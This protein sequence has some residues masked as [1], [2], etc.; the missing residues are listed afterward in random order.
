[1]STS[2]WPRGGARHARRSQVPRP[3]REPWFAT[4]EEKERW[5]AR[6]RKA[7]RDYDR[8][9]AEQVAAQS[10]GQGWPENWTAPQLNLYR[11][12]PMAYASDQHAA[13][14]KKR[15]AKEDAENASRRQAWA[16][17][18]ADRR[19]SEIESLRKELAASD[20]VQ[21]DDSD[22]QARARNLR[23]M[24]KSDVDEGFLSG[25]WP[26]REGRKLREP[27]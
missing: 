15:R 8:L 6:Y 27:F 11:V 1:M 25:A 18:V 24:L 17:Y 10:K 5:R 19:H 4:Y 2:D 23:K 16:A 14:E 7:Y 20:Q 26:P 3:L 9:I 21:K 13:A 22:L 12:G